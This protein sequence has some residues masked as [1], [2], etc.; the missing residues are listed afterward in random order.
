MRQILRL[1]A[2]LVVP[3]T[4]AAQRADS[5]WLHSRLRI[6]APSAQL[7]GRVATVM[8]QHNDSLALQLYDPTEER[9]VA[10][11]AI[12]R[13]EASQGRTSRGAHAATGSVIGIVVG[14]VAG[15]AS[16]TCSASCNPDDAAMG[17]VIGGILGA[18]VGGIGGAVIG[19]LRPTEH[20]RP[21]TLPQE[22]SAPSGMTIVQ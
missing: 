16:A 8:A 2:L 6:W 19:A 1:L 3:A 13:L 9:Q 20:W 10:Q 11:S 7:S 21:V 14:G 4:V 15:L 22:S 18:I 12:T 17:R 5:L